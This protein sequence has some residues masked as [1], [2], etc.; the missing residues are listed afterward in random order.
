VSLFAVIG[1]IFVA[2]LMVFVLLA[3]AKY[4]EITTQT[5]ELR[6]RLDTLAEDERKLKI[7]YE[8][9]FDVNKV[10]TTPQTCWGCQSRWTPKLKPWKRL[11]AD[12]AE[13]VAGPSDG[14][15]ANLGL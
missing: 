1:F 5:A 12:K 6:A 3:H 4:N 10:K 13:V 15:G 11:R 2:V 7:A 14:Q 9:A 8:D